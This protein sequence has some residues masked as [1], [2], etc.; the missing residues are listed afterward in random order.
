MAPLSAR[1]R[2]PG[3]AAVAGLVQTGGPLSLPL[4]PGGAPSDVQTVVYTPRSA[5]AMTT[6]RP[7]VRGPQGGRQSDN[8]SGSIFLTPEEESRAE[9]AF[10]RHDKMQQGEVDMMDFFVICENL[11]LPVNPD[12]ASDWIGAR[13]EAKGLTLDDFK[14]LYARVLAAQSPAVRQVHNGSEP[15][16]LRE[17]TSTEAGMRAAFRKYAV[18]QQLPVDNL[19]QV[20]QFLNFPDHHGD[21]FDRFVGEWLVLSEKEES[22]SLNF[23]EFVVS[24]NLLIEFCEKQTGGSA[25]Q[26]TR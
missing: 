4:G 16:R 23:H 8:A 10:K 13:N 14:G 21:S 25:E 18:G 24:V 12:V 15:V 6:P 7:V 19:A 11:S 22:G 5:G 1:R 26:G 17:L 2:T 20:F 3:S 9:R